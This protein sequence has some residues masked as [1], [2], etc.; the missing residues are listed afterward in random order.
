MKRSIA[1]S[2]VLIAVLVLL[3]PA[4]RAGQEGGNWELQLFG[5]K[6]TLDNEDPF[7]KTKVGAVDFDQD[8]TVT[9]GLFT[10][11]LD[12]KNDGFAGFRLGYIW[13]S[14]FEAELS[15]DRN[16]AGGSYRQRIVDFDS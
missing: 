7:A 3:A 12:M 14:R 6:A 16:H 4:A 2:T 15:S 10:R 13:T 1:A 5:A 11:S 8:G 9:V